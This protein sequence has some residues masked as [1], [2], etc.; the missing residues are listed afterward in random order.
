M[1]ICTVQGDAGKVFRSP[2]RSVRLLETSSN[3]EAVILSLPPQTV[4]LNSTTQIGYDLTLGSGLLKLCS[5][6]SVILHEV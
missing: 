6:Q 3:N 5:M 1:E 2:W 4:T